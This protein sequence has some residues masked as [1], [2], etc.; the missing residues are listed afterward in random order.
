MLE[1]NSLGTLNITFN[2]TKMW[3]IWDC[4]GIACALATP[5]IMA[6]ASVITTIICLIPLDEEEFLPLSVGLGIYLTLL[7]LAWVS[8]LMAVFTNPG[9]IPLNSE[10]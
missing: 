7:G 6:T 2:N 8:H 9:T 1:W 10:G 5:C 3:F 4:F